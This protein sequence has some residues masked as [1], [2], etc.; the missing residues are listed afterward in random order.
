MVG[1]LLV[2]VVEGAAAAA[3]LDR[4]C[5]AAGPGRKCRRRR[6]RRR[7][8]CGVQDRVSQPSLRHRAVSGGCDWRRRHHPGRDRDGCAADRAA[9][10]AELRPAA[11]LASSLRWG[12]GRHRRIWQLHRHTDGRRR[13]VFRRLLRTEPPRQRHVRRAGAR[14][15]ADAG[16]GGGDRQQPHGARRCRSATRSS[17][18]ACWKH[19]WT[20]PTPTRSSR[21][22]ILARPV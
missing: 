15:P 10:L 18:N 21:Y 7:L 16:A 12:R 1:A 6:D 22:R 5:G 8:G 3:A 4:R 2:Q 19:V 20:S 11:R 13:G 14:R 17:R 9:R